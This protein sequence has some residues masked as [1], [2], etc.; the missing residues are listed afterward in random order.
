[1]EMYESDLVDYY[2]R[3]RTDPADPTL[4]SPSNPRELLIDQ[5]FLPFIL[6]YLKDLKCDTINMLK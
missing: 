1:M 2:D 4:K 5:F 3:A 6:S